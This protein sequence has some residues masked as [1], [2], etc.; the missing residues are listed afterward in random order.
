M[1]FAAD[2]MLGRLA[3]WLRL[4]GYD[5]T[6]LSEA[7]DDEE[8]LDLAT[9][10]RRVLLTRDAALYRSARKRGIRAVFVESCDLVEQLKQLIG[11]LGVHLYDMPFF[12]RC[13][14]CNGKI[15]GA[16]KRELK[17]ELP[18]NVLVEDREFWRCTDCGKI[19][20]EGRHW[21]NIRRIIEEVRDD[22]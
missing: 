21:E 17:G 1:R 7:S 8:L 19:Y 13:P 2:S 11:A 12:S 14:V 6:Y 16:E 18:E 10:D 3:R 5:V 4:S 9:A 20:W 15:K 22:V